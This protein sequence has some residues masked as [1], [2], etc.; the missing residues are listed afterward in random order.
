MLWPLRYTM[1]V[2]KEKKK[3]TVFLIANKLNS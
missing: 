1:Y 2:L 3:I